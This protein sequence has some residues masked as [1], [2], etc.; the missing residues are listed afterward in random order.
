[1]LC[2]EA[3][4]VHHHNLATP[5]LSVALVGGKVA[6]EAQA[7]TGS[8]AAVVAAAV[9]TQMLQT[10]QAETVATAT[11]RSNGSTPLCYKISHAIKNITEV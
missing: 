11:S 2:R 1:V 10:N 6:A 7:K 3:Q 4:A 8:L 5:Q 9:I